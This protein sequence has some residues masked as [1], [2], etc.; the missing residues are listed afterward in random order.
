M[1]HLSRAHLVEK[2]SFACIHK[3]ALGSILV[4]YLFS[5]SIKHMEQK[6]IRLIFYILYILYM[7]SVWTARDVTSLTV[8]PPPPP[9][10]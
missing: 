3:L 10:S 1:Q 5:K 7:Y 9:R 4:I 8:S 2:I 6:Y